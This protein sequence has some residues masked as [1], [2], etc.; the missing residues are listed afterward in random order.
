MRTTLIAFTM[1]YLL[2]AC[3][4]KDSSILSSFSLF[5]SPQAEAE[6]VA[7]AFF[8]AIYIQKDL[9]Q[10]QEYVSPTLQSLLKHYAIPASAQRHLLNLSLTDVTIEVTTA[11]P[12]IFSQF[13]QSQVVTIKLY[14]IKNNQ[15]WIDDRSV[16]LRFSG[17]QWRISEILPEKKRNNHGYSSP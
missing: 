16:K 12:E 7:L 14:G 2:T 13:E 6:A 4:I 5:S 3:D 17:N 8:N 9:Q 10:A 15:T 1:L 11:N